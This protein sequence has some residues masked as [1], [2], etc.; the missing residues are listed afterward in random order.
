MIYDIQVK[1]SSASMEKLLRSL[2]SDIAS[3]ELMT[4][5][6]SGNMLL[7]PTSTKKKK[8]S[9][10]LSTAFQSVSE[11]LFNLQVD[12]YLVFLT[13]HAIL[14]QSNIKYPFCLYFIT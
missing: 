9:P 4:L 12:Y 2:D 8:S 7:T 1:A 5:D 13:H 14:L 6:L 10:S 11:T 3:S